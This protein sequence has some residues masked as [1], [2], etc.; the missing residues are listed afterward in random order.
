MNNREIP[1]YENLYEASMCGDIYSLITKKQLKPGISKNGYLYVSLTKEKK[2]K[3][4]TVHKLIALTFLE[5][6]NK[7]NKQIDHIDGNKTNNAVSNLEWV[8]C[9]ENMKRTFNY[10]RKQG[11][12]MQGKTGFNHNRSKPV[13]QILNNKTI[14]SLRGVMYGRCYEQGRV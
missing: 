7:N 4:F 8:S 14:E 6:N 13:K 12:S 9:S 5:N 2:A 3:T 1:G 10:P 11:K